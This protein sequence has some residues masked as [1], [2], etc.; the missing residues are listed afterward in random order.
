MASNDGPLRI[1]RGF[2]RGPEASTGS[3]TVLSPRNERPPASRLI[4]PRSASLRVEL[5]MLYRAS[6]LARPGTR[7][8]PPDLVAGEYPLVDLVALESGEGTGQKRY[9]SIYDKR[10]RRLK[11]AIGALCHPKHRL[12]TAAGE[13]GAARYRDL[14]LLQEDPDGQGTRRPYVVPTDDEQALDL[15]IEFFTNGWIHALTDREIVGYL[16]LLS[17]ASPGIDLNIMVPA[18]ERV[19]HYGLGPDAYKQLQLLEDFGLV[20]YEADP[21]RGD[22]GVFDFKK[23]GQGLPHAWSIKRD[24]L[25]EVAIDVVEAALA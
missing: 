25:A 7:P 11:S 16:M 2:V 12:L 22:V 24:G 17:K 9:E 15:P 13:S 18:K 1:R 19:R 10:M 21:N 5:T 3:D 6:Q 4:S 8:P 20:S 23:V 14:T